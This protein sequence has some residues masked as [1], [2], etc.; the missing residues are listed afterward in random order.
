[1]PFGQKSGEEPHELSVTRLMT[2]FTFPLCLR[3]IPFENSKHPSKSNIGCGIGG[4]GDGKKVQTWVL[5]P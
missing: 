3:L 5:K 1:M 4:K 2:L